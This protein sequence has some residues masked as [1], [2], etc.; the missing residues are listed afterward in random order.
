MK[1]KITTIILVSIALMFIAD[2]ANSI[3]LNSGSN[4]YRVSIV[5]RFFIELYFILL[6]LKSTRGLAV[7]R[8]ILIFLGIFVIGT[9]STLNFYNFNYN[10]FENLVMLNKLLMFFIVMAVLN[11][12]FYSEPSRRQLFSLFEFLILTQA[13]IIILSFIF[14]LDI[15]SAYEDNKRFGY[16]GLIPAQNEI[17]GFFVIAYFYFLNKIAKSKRG[18]FPLFI[19]GIAGLLTGTKV[20]FVIIL[21]TMLYMGFWLLKGRLA[22]LFSFILIGGIVGLI[23]WINQDYLLDRISLTIN[24]IAARQRL[25]FSTA[26]ILTGGRIELIPLFFEFFHDANILSYLFGGYDLT[27][28]LIEMDVFDIFLRLGLI[29]GVFFYYWYIRSL[30][31]HNSISFLHLLFVVAWLGISIFA[32]HIVFS[33]INATYLAILLLSLRIDRRPLMNLPMSG[34]ELYGK[35]NLVPSR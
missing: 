19:V 8:N 29:G 18:I 16:Q 17:S 13:I 27:T 33:A 35:E 11:R 12:Y 9:L 23:V 2:G 28:R 24:Y 21:S 3:L 34:K 30:I 6:L 1:I 22:I 20:S 5:V 15:F 7:W 31:P 10:I 14:D 4:F 25:G 26:Y 32:G